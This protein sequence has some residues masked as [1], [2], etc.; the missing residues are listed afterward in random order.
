[1]TDRPIPSRVGTFRNRDKAWFNDECRRAYLEKQEAYNFWKWNRSPL[2]WNDYVRIKSV[3]QE[4]YGV[5][6]TEYNRGIRKTL[7]NATLPHKLWSIF[8]SALFGVDNGMP[9]L[10]KPAVLT[11]LEKNQPC[12]ETFLMKSK[13]LKNWSFRN[14]VIERLSWHQL[15][16]G[17]GK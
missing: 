10:L 7:V 8:K 14:F 5:A 6:D 4:V 9:P 15:S 16:L 11:V 3:T 2:T 1:M 12:W 13:V 17:L